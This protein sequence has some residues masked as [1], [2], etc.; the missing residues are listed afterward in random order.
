MC[1]KNAL[2]KKALL[3]R[4]LQFYIILTWVLGIFMG[5]HIIPMLTGDICWKLA[6]N[7]LSHRHFAFLLVSGFVPIA[8]SVLCVLQSKANMLPVLCFIKSVFF[9]FSIS[10]VASRFSSGT[11]LA[12][13]LYLFTDSVNVCLLLWFWLRQGIT[14][15]YIRRDAIILTAVHIFCCTFDCFV[16]SP[17]IL[18]L[19]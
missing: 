9:G 14:K 6:D 2:L 19:F 12:K 17:F 15:H 18:R 7:I 5:L 8:L 3:S 16:L 4:S 10:L 11:W 13:I 1:V